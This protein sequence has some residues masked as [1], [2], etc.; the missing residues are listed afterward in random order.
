MP[1]CWSRTGCSRRSTPPPGKL[2]LPGGETVLCSDTVGFVQRLPH[3]LVEAFQSTLEE[4]R[5]ADLLVHVVD[6]TAPD[7]EAQIA[8]VRAVLDEIDAGDVPELLVVN[9]IDAG[10]ARIGSSELS[11][12]PGSV[13]V[14]ARTGAGVDELVAAIGERLRARSAP[15]ELVVPYDRGDVLAALH[16]DGE[17]LVEVHAEDGTRVHARLGARGYRALPRVLGELAELDAHS[18]RGSPSPPHGPV[19]ARTG[20]A[21]PRLARRP[22][23]RARMH[24]GSLARMAKAQTSR[25]FVPPPYPQDRLADLR[26]IADAL[27]GGIVDCSVGTPVDPTPQVALDAARDAAGSAMGY[28]PSIG[29]LPLRDRGSRMDRPSLR[30][31]RGRG[32]GDRVRRHQGGRGE[33]PA[34]AVAPRP[35][36]RSRALPGDLVPHLR[37]GR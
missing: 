11:R 24:P 23:C 4:V 8:A 1:T 21:D 25:G 16:R 6:A 10:R 33:P 36:P 20:V 29:S 35:E 14:S 18:T 30:R 2:R 3:Q 32:R 28:P 31:R 15:V 19:P 27:P 22:P 13:A 7:A 5:E 9:K 34:H 37:D 17:V 12:A 26:V